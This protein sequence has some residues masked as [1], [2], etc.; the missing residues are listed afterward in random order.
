MASN[1]TKSFLA[2][3]GYGEQE[4]D[5]NS[6]LMELDKGCWEVWRPS[7]LRGRMPITVSARVWIPMIM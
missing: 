6:A 5:A 3:A 7:S 2:D 1:S 4:L